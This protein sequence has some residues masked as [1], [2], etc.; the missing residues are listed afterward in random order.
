MTRIIAG[1]A[2]G[3]RLLVPPTGTRPTSDRVRE[4]MFSSWQ[5]SLGSMA[6]TRIADLYSGSGAVGLEALS[7]GASHALLVELDRKAAEVIKAN[8]ASVGLAGAQLRQED[9]S[10]TVRTAPS[11]P[12]DLMFLDPP[13]EL[14]REVLEEVLSNLV[15]Q[16]W[17]TA[18]ATVVIERAVRTAVLRWPDG[19]E[20]AE[21]KKYGDTALVTGI[22][23]GLDT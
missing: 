3:R 15:E 17:L 5:S 14:A 13:Y 9:V 11:A 16:C 23:Y 6:G 4:A 1:S 8:I 19:F 10:R 22:W 18:G 12:Y 20:V 21:P 7:R 2:R